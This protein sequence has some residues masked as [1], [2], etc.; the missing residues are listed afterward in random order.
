MSRSANPTFIG[1]FVLIATALLLGL[2]IFFG[3]LQFFTATKVF[4]LYFDESVNG[5]NVGSLVKFKGV[6]IGRVSD[7]RIRYDQPP[8]SDAV[9][10]FV[11]L[12]LDRI[13][14]AGVDVDLSDKNT[15]FSV[16]EDGLRAQLVVESLIT[17][18]LYIEFDYYTNPGPPEFVGLT[19]E[20]IEIP[21][22]KSPFAD[23]GT[24]ANEM[25]LN[26][27]S[28]DYAGIADDLQEMVRTINNSLLSANLEDISNQLISAL[29]RVNDLLGSQDVEVLITNLSNA[30]GSVDELARSIDTELIPFL[31][32]VKGTLATARS[33]LNSI[34][35]VSRSFDANSHLMYQ[36]E[37]MLAEVS[38]AAAAIESLADFLERNPSALISGRSGPDE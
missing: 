27:A 13:T 4:V 11:E 12:D 20:I 16:I 6:P 31:R 2:I 38:D 10:V 22:I 25:L 3:S 36:L 8:Q 5:L 23:I 18:L 17:G 9:P 37:S 32:D 19:D 34:G 29:N 35:T 15:V 33:T 26:L 7:I 1:A 28:I 24:T 21:T 14:S 30:S